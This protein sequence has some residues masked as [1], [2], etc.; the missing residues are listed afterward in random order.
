M[1]K[2][3][4]LIGCGNIGFRHLEGIL[5]SKFSLEI[6]IIEKS[7]KQIEIVKKKIRNCD[8][9]NIDNIS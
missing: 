7:K 8:L 9:S 1:I 6:I 2:K 5:K 3:I 4:L